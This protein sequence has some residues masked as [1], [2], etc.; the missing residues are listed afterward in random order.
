MRNTS[1]EPATYEHPLSSTMMPT[2]NMAGSTSAEAR[3]AQDS[4]LLDLPPEIRTRIYGYIFASLPDGLQFSS[5]TTK[6]S[7]P[8][9]LL[10]TCY[11]L[12]AEVN[13][14]FLAFLNKSRAP[15]IQAEKTE[16]KLKQI[17]PAIDHK[18]K[19]CSSK[20]DPK[21][22][23]FH[24]VRESKKRQVDGAAAMHSTLYTRCMARETLRVGSAFMRG[25]VMKQMSPKM[26]ALGKR[27][28]TNR[29]RELDRFVWSL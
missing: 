13:G 17:R 25:A 11:F 21:Y 22:L 1:S 19:D 6:D 10:G 28:R 3:P 15:K 7:E 23:W 5:A 26:W 8:N 20:W 4:P 16:E 24:P 18:N 12:R 27:H 2:T 29:E 14:E 9:A